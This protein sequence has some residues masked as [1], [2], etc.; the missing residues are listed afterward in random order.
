MQRSCDAPGIRVQDGV[1]PS[2]EHPVVQL[3]EPISPEQG[4][5]QGRAIGPERDISGPTGDRRRFVAD[6]LHAPSLGDEQE[7]VAPVIQVLPARVGEHPRQTFPRNPLRFIDEDGT[8]TSAGEESAHREGERNVR[9][10]NH[11]G[12]APSFPAARTSLG[13]PRP[14]LRLAAQWSCVRSRASARRSMRRK[15]GWKASSPR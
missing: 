15:R 3:P 7:H 4:I 2:V 14:S 6:Q 10:P 1:R 9:A 11:S 12:E 8:R 5:R 13:I